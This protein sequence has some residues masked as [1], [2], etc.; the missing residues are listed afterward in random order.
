MGYDI[1]NWKIKKLENLKVPLNAFYV[2]ERKDWHPTE[3]NGG[4]VSPSGHMLVE[5]ECGCDQ[6]IKGAF[7]NG[8]LEITE[9]DMLG[10]GSGTFINWILE[11]ALKNSTGILEVACVWEGGDLINV[12]RVC[13]GNVEWSEPG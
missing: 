8:I 13:D 5:L 2:H 3:T 1:T 9:I 11:P 6:K 4:C 7:K 12:L 10:E